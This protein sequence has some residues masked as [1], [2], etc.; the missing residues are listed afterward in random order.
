MKNKATIATI[1]ILSIF[2]LL[3]TSGFIYLLTNSNSIHFNFD[4]TNKPMNLVDSYEVAHADIYNIKFNLHSTDVEIRKSTDGKI[5]VEYY[6]NKENNPKIEYT[7]DTIIIDETKYDLSCIGFCNSRRKVVL[8]IPEYTSNEYLYNYEIATKSGDISSNIDLSNGK[9]VFS[10]MS[11]DIKLN[12]VREAIISTMSGDIEINRVN[13]KIN[14]SAMSGDIKINE[15]NI[16]ED[17]DI[18]TS[19]GDVKVNNNIA[20]CYVDVK[21]SSGDKHIN[22]SDRKS[23]VVLKINTS[24]GDVRVD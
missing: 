15:L 9:V 4:F 5:L 8:Y 14:L 17:S 13:E 23:D 20:N 19:S 22:K 3:L 21:T 11:G 12:T 24:S 16:I 1:I 10:A 18:K 7:E 6:S 2:C